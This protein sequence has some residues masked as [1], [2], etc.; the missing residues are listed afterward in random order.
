MIA[1]RYHRD[2]GF[3]MIVVRSQWSVVRLE[4]AASGP[5]LFVVAVLLVVW[6]V[7]YGP[8]ATPPDV[9]LTRS[10]TGKSPR[11]SAIDSDSAAVPSRCV[12]QSRNR[13]LSM[14]AGTARHV[15]PHTSRPTGGPDEGPSSVALPIGTTT[16]M[17]VA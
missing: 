4:P 7:H 1:S 13:I 3:G 5:V 10:A 12:N 17:V 6:H 15:P 14:P 11:I 16:I 9:W 2:A 8:V